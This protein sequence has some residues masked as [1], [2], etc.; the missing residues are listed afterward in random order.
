MY[1][2]NSSSA[3]SFE[4]RIINNRPHLV[5]RMVSLESDSVMNDLLYPA[6]VVNQSFSQLHNLSAPAGHPM[7]ND[8]FVSASNPLAVN[9]HNVGGIVLNPS[10]D[11]DGRVINELAIDLNVANKDSRGQEIVKRIKNKEQIGVSTGLMITTTDESG[12]S[13][14]RNY[15]AR[16]NSMKFDHV[17]ILL[18]ETPA[19]ENTFTL[20]NE[21]T[22]LSGF[23]GDHKQNE[24]QSMDHKIDIGHLALGD[25][26][27]IKSL[28][29]DQILKALNK[30]V[31]VEEATSIV[32]NSGLSVNSIKKEEIES[33]QANKKDF[34]SFIAN[35]K[36]EREKLE[37]NLVANSDFS[38]EEV[39]GMSDEF[40]LKLLKMKTPD[41]DY[42]LNGS[43]TTNASQS[44]EV[45]LLED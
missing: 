24:E 27:T 28:N 10:I 35:K 12:E 40:L 32:E 4:E 44:T 25:R 22:K 11:K 13:K 39:S 42:S 41:Q 3:G 29:A 19:G 34:D 33:Y 2:I 14:G 15:S 38:K 8:E 23:P 9:S 36:K 31:T 20:N 1:K 37:S 26:E 45:K 17:A 43:V 7:V 30:V 21:L 18:N 5:T 6:D 16:I